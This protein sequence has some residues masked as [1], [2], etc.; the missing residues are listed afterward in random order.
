MNFFSHIEQRTLG[1]L[2]QGTI[3][4][5]SFHPN[6]FKESLFQTY[7]IHKPKNYVALSLKRRA[8]FLAGRYSD[9]C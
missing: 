2:D 9:T 3:F 8:E 4:E 6:Y 5:C 7:Q 1:H